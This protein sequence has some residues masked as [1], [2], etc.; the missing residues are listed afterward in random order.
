MNMV[1]TLTVLESRL[2]PTVRIWPLGDSNTQ[3]GFFNQVS[4]RYPFWEQLQQA[5]YTNVDLVGRFNTVRNEGPGNPNLTNYPNYY[6]TFDRD[7]GGYVGSTGYRTDQLLGLLPA[8][9]ADAQP[10]IVM[11]MTGSNDIGQMGEAGVVP[12]AANLGLIIDGLRTVNP[13]VDILLAAVIPIGPSATFSNYYTTGGAWIDDFN[14]QVAAVATAKNTPQSPV[15]FVD[16]FTNFNLST[17]MSPD[18]LHPNRV[19]EAWVANNFFQALVPL[20]PAPRVAAVAVNDGAA[21]RSRV[22]QIQVS[23]DQVVT[24]PADPAGAF[25]LQRQGDNGVVG[26]TA[27]VTADATT[28]V[29]LTFSGALSESGSLADGRYTLTVLANQVSAGG[30]ALDGNGDGQPGGDHVTALHRLYGDTNGD[31]RVDSADF[32][33]L[34]QTFGRGAADPLFLAYLDFNGDGMVDALD[35]FQF[36]S[37]FGTSL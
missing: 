14:A 13:T 9:A 10:D 36:R 25:R 20:F 6:T 5:G 35:Y 8:I 31:R 21:Q 11:L 23:F 17:H 22:T 2:T 34:R 7:H 24:L 33:L 12:A 26:L 15:V 4:Y 37:R 19:G 18:G 29:T 28:R 30:R 27:A 3:G 1:L 32:F 16:Q